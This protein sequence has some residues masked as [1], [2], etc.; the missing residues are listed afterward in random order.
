MDNYKYTYIDTATT[1]AVKTSQGYL[2]KIV[3]GTAG[4]GAVE[5]WDGVEGGVNT[6]IGELKASIAEGSYEFNCVFAKGLQ[7]L[8]REGAGKITVIY[9]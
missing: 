4:T 8:T 2:H 6:K 3:V 5:L 1:T 7:I 9:R